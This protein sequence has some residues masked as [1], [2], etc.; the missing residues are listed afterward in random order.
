MTDLS[1]QSS[2]R[3]YVAGR[4]VAGDRAALLVR[5]IGGACYSGVLKQVKRDLKA[6][7]LTPGGAVT[8]RA[9]AR[10]LRAG[11]LAGGRITG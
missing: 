1:L 7:R 2:W 3:R 8:V 4:A 11:L 9:A 10:S 6:G 5:R